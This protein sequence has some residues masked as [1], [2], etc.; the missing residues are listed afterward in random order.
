M[1]ELPGNVLTGQRRKLVH[2]LAI[3][4]SLPDRSIV[5]LDKYDITNVC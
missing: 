5:L 3:H 2:G 1:R 4:V